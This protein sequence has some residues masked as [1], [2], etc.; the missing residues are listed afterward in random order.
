[1]G[2]GGGDRRQQAGWA[3]GRQG[4]PVCQGLVLW[5]P[6]AGTSRPL[7]CGVG[8]QGRRETPPSSAGL[9]LQAQPS[10][11]PQLRTVLRH[12]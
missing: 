11:P 7:S 2:V 6:E 8:T 9:A 12:Q 5:G 4:V 3:G 10:P 1:M